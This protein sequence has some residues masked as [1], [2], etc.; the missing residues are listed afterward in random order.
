[1]TQCVLRLV[2]IQAGTGTGVLGSFCPAVPFCGSLLPSL[3]C[4]CTALPYF[5]R[6]LLPLPLLLPAFLPPCP[7]PPACPHLPAPL[8]FSHHGI[9]CLHATVLDV[10]RDRTLGVLAGSGTGTG[11]RRRRTGPCPLPLPPAT[12]ATVC[13]HFTLLLLP[14]PTSATTTPTPPPSA[15]LAIF[16]L[17]WAGSSLAAFT[18]AFYTIS[19]ASPADFWPPPLLVYLSGTSVPISSSLILPTISYSPA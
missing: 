4:Y 11:W 12:P 10:D 14:L 16:L 18:L 15:L 3:P 6:S 2:R 13:K 8:P 9:L 1:M 17:L 19:G 5:Y 7:F